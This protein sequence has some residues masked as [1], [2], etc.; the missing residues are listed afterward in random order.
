MWWFARAKLAPARELESPALKS[1][2]FQTHA[3][4]W[5]SLVTLV[6]I[7]LNSAFGWWWADTVAALGV[8]ALVVREAAEA[9]RGKA[10]C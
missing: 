2:A 1:D 8:V 6:G 10:C 7:G 9:W 5:L 4:W 3:C